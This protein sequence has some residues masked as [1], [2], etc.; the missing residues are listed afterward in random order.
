MEK[1]NTYVD[2]NQE[3]VDRV[4]S[5][6]GKYAFFVENTVLEYF[7]E[8]NCELTQVGGLLDSKGYGVALPKNSKYRQAFNS[9]ILQLQEK[10]VLDDL[11][12]KWWKEERK[13]AQSCSVS[14]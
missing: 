12:R 8:R 11:K 1:Y 7:E 6:K 5:E 9:A 2:N 4:K 13:G 3:G 10:G 14:I